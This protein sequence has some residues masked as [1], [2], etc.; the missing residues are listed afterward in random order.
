MS[1]P[2]RSKVTMRISR[3][4]SAC[5]LP[6]LILLAALAFLKDYSALL[7]L[8]AGIKSLAQLE[9]DTSM[10]SHREAI[11]SLAAENAALK[12]MCAYPDTPT[13]SD[14]TV[15]KEVDRG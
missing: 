3:Q 2:N 7:L 9:K 12:L 1:M 4:V 11:E 10:T 6:N 14:S 8:V 13:Q 15:A 5:C